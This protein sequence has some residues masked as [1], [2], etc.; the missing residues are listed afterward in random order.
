ME[1]F[2]IIG[3]RYTIWVNDLRVV[4]CIFYVFGI[5]KY[6]IYIVYNVFLVFLYKRSE[7]FSFYF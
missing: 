3:G 1:I 7:V 2:K 6:N 4:Y 5:L